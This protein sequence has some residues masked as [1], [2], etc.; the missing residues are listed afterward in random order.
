MQKSYDYAVCDNSSYAWKSFL[1]DYPNHKEAN[2]IR[3]IIRLEVD[4]I[5]E[6]K[7]TGQIPSF[8]QNSYGNSYTSSVEITNNTGCSLTVRYS[9]VDVK[10]IEIPNGATRRINFSSGTYKVAASACSENYARTESLQG[11]YSSNFYIETR[12]Y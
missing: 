11:N 3:D 10:M 8:N 7:N 5:M 9:G 12:R 2:A 6:N 1:E 4:E